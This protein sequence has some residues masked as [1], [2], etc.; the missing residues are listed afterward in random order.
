VSS[1]HRDR[2]AFQISNG[3]NEDVL[4][5]QKGMP[6]KLQ[7]PEHGYFNSNVSLVRS[8]AARK[9]FQD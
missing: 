3:E 9:T 7:E 6:Q 5:L 8:S 4:A 1:L 2:D